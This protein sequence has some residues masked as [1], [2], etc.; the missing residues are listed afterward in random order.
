MTS[1]KVT[2]ENFKSLKSKSKNSL[3]GGSVQKNI[4]INGEN[5]D[6]ILH[7]II[8]SMELAM[9][10]ISNDQTLKSDT[11]QDLKVFNSQSLATQAKKRTTSVSLMPFIKKAFD[12]MGDDIVKLSTENEPLKHKLGSYDEKRFEDSKAKLFKQIDDEKRASLIMSGMQKQLK[13]HS[14]FGIYFLQKFM[15]KQI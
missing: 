8:L 15:G 6:E 5:L 12:K 2:R 1:K 10:N 14:I 7:N 11:V 9:Q 3:E 4:E 13:K